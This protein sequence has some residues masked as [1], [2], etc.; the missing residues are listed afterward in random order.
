MP[1]EYTYIEISVTNL[2]GL[3]V[4][5]VMLR[6]YSEYIN[7]FK[8]NI[9]ELSSKLLDPVGSNKPVPERKRIYPGA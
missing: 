7:V 5:S 8:L 9:K 3:N 6:D 4:F 2:Q 1:L